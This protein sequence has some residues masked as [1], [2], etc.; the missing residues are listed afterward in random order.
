MGAESIGQ[1]VL[2]IDA[3]ASPMQGALAVME[4]DALAKIRTIGGALKSTMT[5][6]M[7]TAAAVVGAGVVLAVGAIGLAAYKVGEQFDEAFDIIVAKTGATGAELDGL[8]GSFKEVFKSVPTDAK[9]AAGAVAELNQR[10]GLT[11]APLE[12]IAKQ[13]IQL[14]QLT[15]EDLTGSI[16][17]VSKAFTDWE[18]PADEMASTLDGFYA[19]SQETGVGVTDL[20]GKVQQFGSPLRQ[21][22]FSLD[23]AA[24]MFAVFEKAGVNTGTATSGMKIGLAN[25]IKPTDELKDKLKQLGITAK[26]PGDKLRQIFKVMQDEGIPAA[27]KTGLAMEVFGKR[28]GADMAEAIKQGRF[29]LEDMTDVMN[30][31]KGSIDKAAESTYDLAE[32][33]QMFKNEV[34]VKIEPIAS[35]VFNLVNKGLIALLDNSNIVFPAMGVLLA[36]LGA[37]FIVWAAQSIASATVVVV[38]WVMTQ[39]AA[40]AS[41]ATT[42]AIF[43]LYVAGWISTAAVAV[44]NAAVIVGA[45][46]ATQAAA[47]AAAIAS[48]AAWIIASGGIILAIMAIIAIVA[49]VII[50]WDQL[51]AFIEKYWPYILAVITA[52]LTGIYTLIYVTFMLIKDVVISAL[53]AARDFIVNAWETIKNKTSSAWETMKNAVSKAIDAIVGFAGKILSRVVAAIGDLSSSLTSRGS[54]LINGMYEGITKKFDTV[55]NW[56]GNVGSKALSALGDLGTTLYNAGVSLM[57]GLWGGIKARFQKMLSDLKGFAGKIKDAKGPEPYDRKVLIPNGRALISGLRTGMESEFQKLLG[58]VSGYAPGIQASIAMPE[59]T[60]GASPDLTRLA[61]AIDSLN[62]SGTPGIIDALTAAVNEVTGNVSVAR[63]GRTA[64][65][66]TL[67]TP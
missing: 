66:G 5:A 17:A 62:A 24:A 16:E 23:E 51:K 27:D 60:V 34:L 29:S 3:D 2:E 49:L 1:A 59:S 48:A 58:D 26:D 28:A 18:V 13:M 65:D 41:G 52:P 37:A 20:A 11:G 35:R 38:A 45:W 47:I 56:L 67:A 22:G 8:K 53:S 30:G 21:L 33:W 44:F 31:G 40:I 43:A 15:G 39:A 63:R 4:G 64:G 32:Q 7:G 10:L 42:L 12:A 61:D 46:V 57:E 36:V 14:S 19:L 50:Y 55:T 54:A 6:S 25:L 9:T